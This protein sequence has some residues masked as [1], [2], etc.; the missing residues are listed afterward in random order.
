[1]NTTKMSVILSMVILQLQIKGR[2]L[3]HVHVCVKTPFR[4]TWTGLAG[5]RIVVV[6]SNPFGN[7]HPFL[8]VIRG[9]VSSSFHAVR[10]DKIIQSTVHKPSYMQITI[11]RFCRLRTKLYTSEVAIFSYSE[12]QTPT[13]FSPFFDKD[14][15]KQC[16]TKRPRPCEN[17]RDFLIGTYWFR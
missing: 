13:S 4:D 15:L 7:L 9:S 1:M 8:E 10:G 17:E 2:W 5:L 12:L 3:V 6:H 14:A 16:F 11:L